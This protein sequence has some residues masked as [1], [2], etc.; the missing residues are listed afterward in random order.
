MSPLQLG[1]REQRT[2]FRPGETM[3]GAAQWE[4][5]AAPAWVELR[6]S[7]CARGLGS[8][9]SEVMET[10]RFENPAASDTRT[11]S[12][13]L[14]PAP[15]SCRGQLF[16]LAWALGLVAAPGK[17][18]ERLEFTLGPE[19]QEIVLPPAPPAGA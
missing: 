6:L 5:P 9:D 14:P 15:Y 11:W 19:G 8:A 7:W 2:Q 4:L 3:A 18:F 16:A 12:L 1:I 17:L 10:Q 13:A